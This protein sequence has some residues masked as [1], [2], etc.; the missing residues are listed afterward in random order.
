MEVP[1]GHNKETKV[2][3][4]RELLATKPELLANPPSPPTDDAQASS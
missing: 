4:L 2:A 3:K 1:T